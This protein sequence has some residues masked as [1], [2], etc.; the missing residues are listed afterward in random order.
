MPTRRLAAAIA[1]SEALR[2][3]LEALVADGYGT[4]EIARRLATEY[5]VTRNGRPLNPCDVRI[6]L[7]RLGL[8]T[9]YQAGIAPPGAQQAAQRAGIDRAIAEGRNPGLSPAVVTA[10][11]RR[12]E[13]VAAWREA[14]RPTLEALAAA[15]CN[16][17]QMLARLNAAGVT[18]ADDRPLHRCYLGPVCAA[19]GIR[20]PRSGARRRG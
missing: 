14:I 1:R 19:L 11:Q 4:R 15:G 13:R 2:E 10:R 7:Q 17:P 20:T 9:A 5:G 12:S 6:H 3:P 18:T 16:Q 8:Q